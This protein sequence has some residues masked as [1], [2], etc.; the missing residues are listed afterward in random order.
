MFILRERA[1]AER[2][3]REVLDRFWDLRL[4]VNV[5][6]IAAGLGGEVGDLPPEERTISGKVERTENG[7][8]I[9]VNPEEPEHRR[10]F[11]IAH[12][13][14][15]VVLGHVRPGEKALRDPHRP[16]SFLDEDAR[17]RAANY[18]AAE[19]LMPEKTVLHAIEKL[20]DPTLANLANLFAVSRSAMEI[21]L[22]HLGVI[23]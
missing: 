11:T 9:L 4:P 20:D 22:R 10:R 19:L 21:R 5:Q 18:F 3:A 15:H 14:G 1:E 13:I 8:R 12:E 6:R 16:W 2:K 23:A 17:E 7:F